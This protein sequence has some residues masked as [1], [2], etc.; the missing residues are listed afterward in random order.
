M[1][2]EWENAIRVAIFAEKKVLFGP[3]TIRVP[4][5]FHDIRKNQE[6][7][8]SFPSPLFLTCLHAHAPK[9]APPQSEALYFTGVEPRRS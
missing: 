3:T 2:R 5:H 6:I 1:Y 8:T 7:E 4:A 9:N